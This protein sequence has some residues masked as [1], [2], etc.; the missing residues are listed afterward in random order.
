MMTVHDSKHID[1][2]KK[3]PVT[4]F[5]GSAAQPCRRRGTLFMS[6]PMTELDKNDWHMYCI[7]AQYLLQIQHIDVSQ[8]LSIAFSSGP[9]GTAADSSSSQ[10]HL[11]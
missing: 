1:V 7:S 11:T 4:I 9:P 5:T 8:W 10:F 2:S 3:N 6:F